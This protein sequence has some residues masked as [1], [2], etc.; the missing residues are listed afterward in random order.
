MRTNCKNKGNLNEMKLRT[1]NHKIIKQKQ[2]YLNETLKSDLKVGCIPIDDGACWI[3]DAWFEIS[4]ALL[5]ERPRM[6]AT[7]GGAGGKK[8]CD[9]FNGVICGASEVGNGWWGDCAW[10]VKAEIGVGLL[11]LPVGVVSFPV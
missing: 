5:D 1:W 4:D 11:K 3:R 6:P 9:G 7:E 2:K 10:L 8:P